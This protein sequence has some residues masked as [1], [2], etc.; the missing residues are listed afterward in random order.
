MSSG[1]VQIVGTGASTYQFQLPLSTLSEASQVSGN[2]NYATG[3]YASVAILNVVATA[4]GNIIFTFSSIIPAPGAGDF[5][6]VGWQVVSVNNVAN[7]VGNIDSPPL[8]IPAVVPYFG[9]GSPK[10]NVTQLAN[11]EAPRTKTGGQPIGAVDYAVVR[12]NG[13]QATDFAT[14][15]FVV[16]PT[17]ITAITPSGN[18]TALA[19]NPPTGVAGTA[20]SSGAQRYY[21]FGTTSLQAGWNVGNNLVPPLTPG[22]PVRFSVSQ[23]RG[24]GVFTASENA[25]Y[26]YPLTNASPPAISEQACR[27]FD[28]DEEFFSEIKTSLVAVIIDD[29]SS[30]PASGDVLVTYRLTSGAPDPDKVVPILASQLI[31]GARITLTPINA[32]QTGDV[33]PVV[34]YD[35]GFNFT[36]IL[37]TDLWSSGGQLGKRTTQIP[38]NRFFVYGSQWLVKV[39]VTS[40][41]RRACIKV[42]DATT[43]VFDEK[44]ALARAQ[45]RNSRV[46][47]FTYQ[48]PAPF[49]PVPLGTPTIIHD[50]A[51]IQAGTST[52]KISCFANNGAPTNPTKTYRFYIYDANGNQY[53]APIPATWA[54]GAPSTISATLT[55]VTPANYTDFSVVA[56]YG[57]QGN[58]RAWATSEPAPIP[59]LVIEFPDL[60]ES[61]VLSN[62]AQNYIAKKNFLTIADVQPDTGVLPP[63][64]ATTLVYN[65]RLTGLTP[66]PIAPVLLPVVSSGAQLATSALFDVTPGTTYSLELLVGNGL[67]PTAYKTI[68]FASQFTATTLVLA[69]NTTFVLT[70]TIASVASLVVPMAGQT[71]GTLATPN[72]ATN[73]Y[74]WLLQEFLGGVYIPFASGSFTY[75]SGLANLSTG[76]V[77]GLNIGSTYAF[78]L[79]HG[80]PLQTATFY[81]SLQGTNFVATNGVN[82]FPISSTAISVSSA[83]NILQVTYDLTNTPNPANPAP[84]LFP[85]A[86]VQ[87]QVAWGSVGGS[88][89]FPANSE[90]MFPSGGTNIQFPWLN[91]NPGFLAYVWYQGQFRLMVD[92]I[93][94]QISSPYNCATCQ[95]ISAIIPAFTT[96]V[97]PAS[98]WTFNVG[99]DQPAQGTNPN[100]GEN[101]WRYKLVYTI[102]GTQFKTAP[103]TIAGGGRSLTWNI[104][105]G[106]SSGTN[107]Y[108]ELSAVLGMDS[109]IF[110]L[111]QSVPYT[112]PLLFP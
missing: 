1:V 22:T 92:S 81:Q 16:P 45:W 9:T 74:T 19:T 73:N 30:A 33:P 43:S 102:A 11:V 72:V 84:A 109:W 66:S 14:P 79:Q 5:L 55:W 57:T 26:E 21:A 70:N 44:E 86:L 18:S 107:V 67:N 52:L 25:G 13:W 64:N 105:G 24:S 71:G 97:P 34:V 46:T 10:T 31:G 104:V 68:P 58:N 27:L 4:T 112:P 47:T 95:G 35:W 98:I 82:T 37:A 76:D 50:E 89:P 85:P 15:E 51:I 106:I 78:S 90:V 80:S 94:A 6:Y 93:Q 56:T 3:A 83:T 17:A 12:L 42:P 20:S 88:S 36:A 28:S 110:S 2:I 101:D 49:V 38:R 54:S 100:P 99:V 48:N 32:T 103:S 91:T 53:G 60:I 108:V 96:P 69:D 65:V 8:A 23:R 61:Y 77:T 75:N 40:A 111:S 41:P 7:L 39:E 29:V 59:P 62:P 63:P 87:Y